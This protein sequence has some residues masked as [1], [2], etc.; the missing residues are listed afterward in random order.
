[1]E[2]MTD[3][4]AGDGPTSEDAALDATGPGTPADIT[5]VDPGDQPVPPQPYVFDPADGAILS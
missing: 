2:L 4:I 5:G 1:M 3:M